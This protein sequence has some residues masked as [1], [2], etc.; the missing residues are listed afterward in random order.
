MSEGLIRQRRNLFSASC[1]LIFLKFAEVEIS[2]LSFLGLDFEKLGN[3]SALYLAIWVFFFYFMFRYYQYY[4]QE[5]NARLSR[6]FYEEMERR[7]MRRVRQLADEVKEQSNF[8]PHQLSTLENGGWKIRVTYDGGEDEVGG[9][10]TEV[11]N[12][13]F[14][15]RELNK[16]R[17]LSLKNMTLHTSAVTDYILPFIVAIGTLLYCGFGASSSLF[18]A[19]KHGFA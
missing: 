18:E 16:Y 12:I 15:I 11:E 3:P 14:P 8:H 19:I 4:A 7:V 1:V 17:I 2:R 13:M 6:Y 5:G 10:K 9:R